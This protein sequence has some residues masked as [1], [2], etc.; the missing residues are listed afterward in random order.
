MIW[1]E[2]KERDNHD[3]EKDRYDDYYDDDEERDE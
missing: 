2:G 1:E 3:G